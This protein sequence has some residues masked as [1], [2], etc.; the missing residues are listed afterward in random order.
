[1]TPHPDRR[2]A[3]KAALAFAEVQLKDWATLHGV[4]RTMLYQVLLG[5]SKSKRLSTAID[6]F[7]AEEFARHAE[8][9]ARATEETANVA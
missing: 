8:E 7:I 3:F 6:R 1:V 4:S 5:R 2:K 9:M